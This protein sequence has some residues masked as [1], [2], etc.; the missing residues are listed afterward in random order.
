MIASTL[1]SQRRSVM[2]E[3]RSIHFYI[4]LAKERIDE[5]DAALASFDVKATEVQAGTKV[6]AIGSSRV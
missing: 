2:S 3:Q 5:M 4:N 6:K 1:A